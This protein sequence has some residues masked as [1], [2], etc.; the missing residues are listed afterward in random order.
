MYLGVLKRVFGVRCADSSKIGSLSD[1]SHT[2]LLACF[3]RNLVRHQKYL[4][5]KL[6]HWPQKESILIL[7][8]FLPKSS[9]LLVWGV[10][11]LGPRFQPSQLQVSIQYSIQHGCRTCRNYQKWVCSK[12][13]RISRF[14]V[15][16]A[17]QSKP[18]FGNP[19]PR[20]KRGKFKKWKFSFS[21][22]NNSMSTS[23]SK[24]LITL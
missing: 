18:Q 23:F 1:T 15:S 20:K 5:T 24:K 22:E 2:P 11:W 10:G 13:S 14:S 17:F 16:F 12:A 6:Q 19:P 4:W 3:S 8:H 21:V 9:R 7:Q